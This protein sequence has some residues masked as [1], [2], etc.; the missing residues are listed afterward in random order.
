MSA[1][2]KS[3][4][5]SREKLIRSAE[6]LF[7]ERGYNGVSVRDISNDAKVNSALV[8]YHFGGKEGL[9]TEVYTLQCEPLKAERAR[10]LAKYTAG[11]KAATLEDILDAFIRPSLTVAQKSKGGKSFSRLRAILSVE[12]SLLLERLVSENFDNTSQI[13]TAALHRCLPGLTRDDV[14]WRFHFLLGATYYTAMGPHRIKAL[15]KGKCDP[16]EPNVTATQLIAF[17]AAGFRAN[18]ASTK[19][20][21][22]KKR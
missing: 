16:S 22:T 11:R 9:L 10:L 21:K 7:A 20:K 12:N 17:A 6:R 18:T 3:E 2:K 15:S 14:Y 1:A 4:E 8:G 13:F 5:T 19:R